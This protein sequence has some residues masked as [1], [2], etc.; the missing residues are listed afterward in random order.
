MNNY[1][2]KKHVEEHALIKNELINLILTSASLDH[3]TLTENHVT[4]YF[5]SKDIP[6][7]YEQLVMPAILNHMRAFETFYKFNGISLHNMWFQVYKNGGFHD[8]HVHPFC[9]FTNV[10]YVKLRDKNLKT[11]IKNPFDNQQIVEVDVEEG[12]IL[13]FPSFFFHKAPTV[14]GNLEKIIISFNTNIQ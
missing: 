7:K 4:D 14:L 6:R 5:I 12:D 2:F 13:T 8:W 3:S 1:F 9:H 11:E 10:Y